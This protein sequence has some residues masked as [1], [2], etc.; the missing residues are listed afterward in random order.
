VAR[1]E[2]SVGG[3]IDLLVD[4]DI[5]KGLLPIVKLTQQIEAL[6]N[7]PVDVAPVDILKPAI[8]RRALSEA[9]PL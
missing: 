4:F 5:S 3:D 9:V 7:L 1:G 6:I 8:A 2:S